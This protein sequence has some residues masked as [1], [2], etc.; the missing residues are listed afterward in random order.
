MLYRNLEYLGDRGRVVHGGEADHEEGGEHRDKEL[1]EDGEDDRLLVVDPQSS[2]LA[3]IQMFLPF[4]G[5]PP[6]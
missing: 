6:G 1:E 2:F 4:I 3:M 5:P